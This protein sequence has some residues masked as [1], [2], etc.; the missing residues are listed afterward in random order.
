MLLVAANAAMWIHSS[1]AVAGT[2]KVCPAG[3]TYSTIQ[4][5]IDAAQTGDSIKIA[6]GTYTENLL[7]DPPVAATKLTLLGTG[8]PQTIV[9]ASQGESGTQIDKGYTVS[10]SGSD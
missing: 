3:C 7:I 6:P 2:L 1:A 8:A 9:D 10:L 4:S 5:A